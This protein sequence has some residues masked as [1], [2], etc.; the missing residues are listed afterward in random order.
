MNLIETPLPGVVIL[1]PKVYRDPRGYFMETWN[2]ARYAALGLPETFVQDNLSYSTRGVL[3]GLH[4][5]H[6]C[7]QGKLVS[8]LRGEVYDVAVDIR[9][10]SP[11]FGRWVGVPLSD[12][13]KRE[14]YIPPGFAHGFVVTSE[15]ALFCYKCTEYYQ[16]QSE[17]S[18]L[19]NDPALGIT[20]PLGEPALSAKDQTAP[21]LADIPPGRLP[22][23]DLDTAALPGRNERL[24][25]SHG[26]TPP[27]HHV[28]G[29]KV[30][31]KPPANAL[32]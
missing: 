28:Q 8:V 23:Y 32:T 24:D 19:W 3:R 27:G 10:G 26:P 9:V 1:E 6:P 31:P 21:R 4:Y 11:T 13:N 18:V 30:V 14:L 17:A 20:W 7:A 15:T 12:E 25:E 29:A 16:P 2:L 5:Q 22:V